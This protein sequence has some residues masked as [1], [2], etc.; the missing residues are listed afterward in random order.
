MK[1][2]SFIVFL[3]A[4]WGCNDRANK[5]INYNNEFPIV[6][7]LLSEPIESIPF[8]NIGGMVLVDTFLV[9][10]SKNKSPFLQVYSSRFYNLIAE[11]AYE[12]RG[13]G[14]F[15]F[16]NLVQNSLND[17]ETG[18]WI[19]DDVKGFYYVDLVGSV[20]SGNFFY[21]HASEI[22]LPD[23]GFDQVN[24]LDNEII[25]FRTYDT[26]FGIL[27]RE[28]GLSHFVPFSAT[29]IGVPVDNNFKYGVY[30]SF[31][32]ANSKQKKVFSAY[33]LLPRIEF[34]DFDG[35]Y[36]KTTVYDNEKYNKEKFKELFALKDPDKVKGTRIY[37]E[38]T[39]YDNNY[40]YLLFNNVTEEILFG[41]DPSLL[42]NSQILIF[43]WEGEPLQRLVLDKF[44]VTFAIDIMQNKIFTYC[45][46]DDDYPIFV[47]KLSG[48]DKKDV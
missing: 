10:L 26:R 35:N 22:V 21:Q 11:F 30:A 34:F 32:G 27:N 37:L 42:P 18:F 31:I 43:N 8:D 3:Y 47:Y 19:F 24:F 9:T 36:L 14:E 16:P 6:R 40:I 38:A 46:L 44:V 13:P 17:Y 4:I 33:R 7:E 15:M 1:Y 45:P 2:F 29:D 23:P 20:L 41:D 12:G 28:S 39:S 5:N 25:G 48:F